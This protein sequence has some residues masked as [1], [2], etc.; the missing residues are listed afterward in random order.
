MKEKIVNI[1]LAYVKEKQIHCSRVI[2]ELFADE[3]IKHGATIPVNCHE[4]KHLTEDGF[5]F[6]D[7]EGVS[8]KKTHIFGYC[9]KGEK[10]NG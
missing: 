5:C 9:D 8:Y 3:L 4:C 7:I 2:L 1:L 6:Q 10:S